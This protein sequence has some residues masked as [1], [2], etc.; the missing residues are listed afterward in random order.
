MAGCPGRRPIHSNRKI[1]WRPYPGLIPDRRLTIKK[2]LA[3]GFIAINLL[4]AAN[5][6]FFT[7]SNVRRKTTVV[8]HQ[9]A[10]TGEKIIA[11]VQ[12]KLI[13]IQKQVALLSE[14]VADN[15][16]GA[17]A[18]DVAQFRAQLDLIR[19][20]IEQLRAS[21]TGEV[22]TRADELSTGY[23]RLSASWLTFYEN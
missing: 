1:K 19:K 12:Q 7:W 22:R 13:N 15:G 18:E 4:F 14:A 3:L 2:R 8:D 20:D 9:H 21:S 11:T 5:V 16:N 23:A 6:A 10:I 17:R